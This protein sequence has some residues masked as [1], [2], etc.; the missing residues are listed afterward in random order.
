[1]SYQRLFP[2]LS[3]RLSGP[4]KRTLL[5]FCAAIILLWPATI[6][7]QGLDRELNTAEKVSL[8]IKNLN[9]RVTVIASDEQKKVVTVQATSP[10]APIEEADVRA[11]ASGE[12][13]DINVR[14]RR[15][16]DRIDITVRIPPRSKVKIEG[17]AGAISV[18]GNVES[19]E[20]V[21]NTGTIHADVPLDNV[22]FNFLWESSRPRYLSDV[23][24]P[25]IKE[26]A[27]GRYTISGKLGL[28]AKKGK[29]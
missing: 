2:Q 16:A 1:M 21:T 7:A 13:V 28:G 29:S 26:R 5:V 3:A 20:V 4:G 24:L 14:E 25:K 22:K 11:V 19:A 9:G 6:F 23:E 17:E 8:S 10:G 12:S 18:L 27:G 15:A